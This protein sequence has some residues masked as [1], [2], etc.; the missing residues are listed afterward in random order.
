M[1]RR[2]NAQLFLQLSLFQKE[3]TSTETLLTRD[4]TSLKSY[5]QLLTK[6]VKEGYSL[7]ALREGTGKLVGVAVGSI[8]L[9]TNEND[10][11]NE[12]DLPVVMST[13]KRIFAGTSVK[14]ELDDVEKYFEI[15]AICV[16]PE[17]RGK[18]IGTALL[19]SCL[20]KTKFLNLQICVGTFISDAI[21]R[22]GAFRFNMNR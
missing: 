6:I 9:K 3:P 15:C 16:D 4:T 2:I 8:V 18:G 11:I 1:D 17:H 20:A 14:N 22:I 19:R 5:R 10:V 12:D 13:K 7:C 21:Q